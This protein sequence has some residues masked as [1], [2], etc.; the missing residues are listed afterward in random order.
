[1]YCP[2]DVMSFCDDGYDPAG[3]PDEAITPD[4]YWIN[5][6][7]ND[8]IEEFMGYIHVETVVLLSREK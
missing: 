4:N 8:V 5:T 7:G 3:E 1:M 6:S 2:W